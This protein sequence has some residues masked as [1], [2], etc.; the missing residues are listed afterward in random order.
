MEI[1]IKNLCHDYKAK[2]DKIKY[3]LEQAIENLSVKADEVSVIFTSDEKIREYNREYRNI[4]H[5]TDVL[6]FPFGERNLEGKIN[7]GD[8]IISIDAAKRQAQELGHS[9]DEELK[10]LI[11]HG[12]LH[13]LNYDHEKDDGEMREKEQELLSIL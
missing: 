4:D 5:E 9:I 1:L 13:L 8:I 11:I 7:L 10:I 3:W 6:S 2:K 12:L